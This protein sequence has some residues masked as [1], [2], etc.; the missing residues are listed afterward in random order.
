VQR[1]GG[2]PPI[3]RRKLDLYAAPIDAVEPMPETPPPSTSA[4]SL[5]SPDK[6]RAPAKQFFGSLRSSKTPARRPYT[7]TPARTATPSTGSRAEPIG[8]ESCDEANLGG[9]SSGSV[10]FVR[11]QNGC[12]VSQP[13]DGSCLF[14][15]LSFGLDDGSDAA[16]SR[17]EISTFIAENP[18]LA[19]AGTAL[20]DWVKFDSGGG[21]DAYAADIAGGTWGG[22]I[23]ME[24]FVRLK[25]VNVHVY[26]GCLGGYRRICCFDGGPKASRIVNVLYR[27]RGSRG[28]EHYDALLLGEAAGQWLPRSNF[29]PG[30]SGGA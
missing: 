28:M 25:G 11:E 5:E 1:Y 13:P 3:R 9:D 29:E 4:S 27:E 2:G 14:H 17:L 12:I 19:I 6:A 16:S 20:K 24:V 21:V 7:N 8:L 10:F 18:D 26:E 30:A 22:G 15:S 23:E